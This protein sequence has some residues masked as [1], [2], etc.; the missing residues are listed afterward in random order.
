MKIEYM[1]PN[2]Y[3][4]VLHGTS[5]MSI[6][7]STGTEVLHTNYKVVNNLEELK[8]VVDQMPELH[9]QLDKLLSIDESD[10]YAISVIR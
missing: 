4:G 6:Y 3:R 7:D 5:S 1:S 8:T 2:G 9:E 10:R